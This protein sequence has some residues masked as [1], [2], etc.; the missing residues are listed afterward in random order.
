MCVE[1]NQITF[2]K[3]SQAISRTTW[4]N[5]DLFLLIFGAFLMSIP[6][7]ST[8]FNNGGGGV[9]GINYT[10]Q[11][12]GVRVRWSLTLSVP[13]LNLHWY[14]KV[15]TFWQIFMLLHNVELNIF[16]WYYRFSFVLLCVIYPLMM[17]EIKINKTIKERLTLIHESFTI[18]Q[19]TQ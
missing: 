12:L 11:S 16:Y 5:I 2:M 1:T 17:L 14:P 9:E 8:V 18:A 15:P 3:I 13:T 4:P 7:I 19:N 6:N 10:W